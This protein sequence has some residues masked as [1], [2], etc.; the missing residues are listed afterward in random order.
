[1]TAKYPEK[2]IFEVIQILINDLRQLQYRLTPVLR[3]TEFLYNKI[4]TAYQ[5]SLA[6]R[7]AVSDPPADL[8]QLIH[9][10]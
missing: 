6:C 8:G 10:L 3:S 5:G 7:Y 2:S 1:M 4:V 9:K